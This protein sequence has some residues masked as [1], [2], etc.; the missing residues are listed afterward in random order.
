MSDLWTIY[1]LN[2]WSKVWKSGQKMAKKKT[3]YLG[4]FSVISVITETSQKGS[5]VDKVGRY[6]NVP[7][8]SSFHFHESWYN[9]AKLYRIPK[10]LPKGM[11]LIGTTSV[12]L[13]LSLLK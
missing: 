11:A 4:T 1:S 5:P 13:V 6:K 7:K 8:Y 10:L 3:E 12:Q 2:S 9:F